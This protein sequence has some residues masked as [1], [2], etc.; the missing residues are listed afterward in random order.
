MDQAIARYESA[1]LALENF[2]QKHAQL[3]QKLGELE[4]ESAEALNDAKAFYGEH[5][6]VVGASY[7]GFSAV[8]KRTVDADKLTAAMP[9][10]ISVVKQSMPMPVFDQLC[11]EGIIPQQLAADVVHLTYTINGPRK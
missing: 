8:Q 4:T 5:H 1:Q 10:L 7:G 6:T 2:R 11:A 3:M 9:D